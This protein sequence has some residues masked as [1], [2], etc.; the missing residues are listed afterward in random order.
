MSALSA[1]IVLA[2]HQLDI[3]RARLQ[4]VLTLSTDVEGEARLARNVVPL[5]ITER[6]RQ[7]LVLLGEGLSN[8]EIAVRLGVTELR[9]KNNLSVLYGKL[10]V[11]GRVEA[12]L[13][14]H[15]LELVPRFAPKLKAYVPRTGLRIG[16]NNRLGPNPDAW[17]R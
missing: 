16:R 8:K 2:I 3:V 4:D 13:L 7:L 17:R 14:G 15:D 1:A 10:G 12:A 5:N 6:Q 11:Q 9:V